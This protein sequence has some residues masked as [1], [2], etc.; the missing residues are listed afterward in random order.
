M[1][2]WP[3]ESDSSSL[4]LS[5]DALGPDRV[6]CHFSVYISV[7]DK[8]DGLPNNINISKR[9]YYLVPNPRPSWGC[10]QSLQQVCR[11]SSPHLRRRLSCRCC[12]SFLLHLNS[13]RLRSYS[14][15]RSLSRHGHRSRGKPPS[16]LPLEKFKINEIRLRLRKW[17]V[18]NIIILNF[19]T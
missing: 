18:K 19:Q 15:G 10:R 5:S 16:L 11:L 17:Y 6:I 14:I 2:G 9:N 7:V 3:A 12:L 13:S 8:R 4:L 1:I